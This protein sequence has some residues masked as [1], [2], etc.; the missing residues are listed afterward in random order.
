MAGN[1]I[2]VIVAI[3]GSKESM[4]SL[5]LASTTSSSDPL[6]PTLQPPQGSSSYDSLLSSS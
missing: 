3:D 6:C 2:C 1:L 4:N 5:S